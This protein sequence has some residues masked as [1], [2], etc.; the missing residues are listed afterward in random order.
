MRIIQDLNQWYN[1][2]G[3][4]H[5]GRFDSGLPLSSPKFVVLQCQVDCSVDEY[6]EMIT[7]F[8]PTIP[9]VGHIACH[10]FFLLF[11]IVSF[12]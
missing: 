9:A 2:V 5:I 7:I 6:D 8:F 12:I 11:Y 1:A 10:A 3:V 4:Q